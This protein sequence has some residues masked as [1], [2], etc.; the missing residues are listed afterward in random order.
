MRRNCPALFLVVALFSA[1]GG[2][3]ALLQIAAWSG[4]VVRYSTESG[5]RRGLVRTFSGK[6]PCPM[7]RHVARAQQEQA[8][9]E[10]AALTVSATEREVFLAPA[11]VTL[12]FASWPVRPPVAPAWRGPERHEPVPVPPPRRA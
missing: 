7:C 1:T 11:P 9:N 8:K 10:P 12:A 6:E 4:M 5:L 3:L 2:Q